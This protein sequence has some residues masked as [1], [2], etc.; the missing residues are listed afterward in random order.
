MIVG[1]ALHINN[2][3]FEDA[4]GESLEV[5]LVQTGEIFDGELV[6]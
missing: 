2:S 1:S 6:Q 3:I 5:V 4:T